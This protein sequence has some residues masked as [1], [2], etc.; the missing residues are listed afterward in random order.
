MKVIWLATLAAIMLAAVLGCGSVD[1][2]DG[3]LPVSAG[4]FV[5]AEG[6]VVDLARAGGAPIPGS[7]VLVP[8]PPAPPGT[9]VREGSAP[10]SDP[11]RLPRGP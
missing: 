2:L 3:G 7:V 9:L 11:A 5:S 10:V 1:D 6:H 8:A 4:G